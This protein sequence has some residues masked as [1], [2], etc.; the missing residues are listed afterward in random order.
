MD[1]THHDHSLEDLNETQRRVHRILAAARNPLSAY[2]VLDKM[3]G[4]AAVTPPTVYRSLDKLI[5]KGLAH[6][7]ESLN[8]YV[9]CKHPHHHEMA[10]FAICESCG[11]VTEFS[12]P[13]ISDRLLQWSDAHAFCP[14]KMTVEVRGLCEACAK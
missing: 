10:A 4:K 9:A 7:L 6:R 8:A 2:E 1:S 5:R 12:D 13:Q 3:R 14:K 11:A